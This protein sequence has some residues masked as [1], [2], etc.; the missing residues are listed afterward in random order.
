M[1]I[2]TRVTPGGTVQ[3]LKR[4]SLHSFAAYNVKA[5]LALRMRATG[6]DSGVAESEAVWE[7]VIDPVGVFDG[8][9]RG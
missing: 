1:Y 4:T 7:R 6:L 2:E 3:Y 5:T 9:G 8:E